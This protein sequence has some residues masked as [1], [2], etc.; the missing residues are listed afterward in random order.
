MVC[1][2][3]PRLAARPPAYVIRFCHPGQ[4]CDPLV[5]WEGVNDRGDM[6]A[7]VIVSGSLSAYGADSYGLGPYGS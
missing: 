4:L 5:Y 6:L 2:D 3:Q 1:Y 7:K